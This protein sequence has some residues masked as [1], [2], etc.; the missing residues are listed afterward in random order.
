MSVDLED[1]VSHSLAASK[2]RDP[3]AELVEVGR[4]CE[5]EDVVLMALARAGWLANR[6]DVFVAANPDIDLKLT[7]MRI[8][9]P[10]RHY[11]CFPRCR[12]NGRA[13]GRAIA[14]NFCLNCR[15]DVRR[16]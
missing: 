3:R 4:N 15:A 7:G 2:A 1:T 13:R 8:I 11:I 12:G 9:P 6:H 14:R 16:S 5:S 10:E